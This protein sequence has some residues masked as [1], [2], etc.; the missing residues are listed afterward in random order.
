[1]GYHFASASDTQ[2]MVDYVGSLPCILVPPLSGDQSLWYSFIAKI[3]GSEGKFVL[4]ML[5]GFQN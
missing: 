5:N 2:E 1:M 3:M 4:D